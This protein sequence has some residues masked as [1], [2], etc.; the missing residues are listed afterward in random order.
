MR[1]GGDGGV[2][3]DA[4]VAQDAVGADAA[5][6][7][8]CDAAFQY[9]VDVYFYVAAGAYFA[10]D[11][12]AGRVR[13]SDAAFEEGRR[14]GAAEVAVGFFEVGRGVDARAFRRASPDGGDAHAVRGRQRRDVGEVAFF[15]AVVGVD[16]G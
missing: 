9:Y 13:Q 14:A 6:V 2:G 15:C 11:V 12:Y 5:V 4:A 3:A 16:A 10:A 1:E 8:Q 7:A